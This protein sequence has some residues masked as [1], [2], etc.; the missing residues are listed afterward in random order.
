M[1]TEKNLM[2][3]EIGNTKFKGYFR[4]FEH[5]GVLIYSLWIPKE[6]PIDPTYPKYTNGT[7]IEHTNLRIE[8]PKEWGKE[9]VAQTHLFFRVK[10]VPFEYTHFFLIE[11][12]GACAQ[13]CSERTEDEIKLLLV[14][15]ILGLADNTSVLKE[16]APNSKG[17]YK[18]KELKVGYKIH[19]DVLTVV[20]LFPFS[21]ELRED[22]PSKFQLKVLDT[23]NH[24]QKV[25]QVPMYFRGNY[26]KMHDHNRFEL[27]ARGETFRICSGYDRG[28]LQNLIHTYLKQSFFKDGVLKDSALVPPVKEPEKPAFLLS[29]N[30]PPWYNLFSEVE[31]C[32]K[33]R[34]YRAA[35]F[36]HRDVYA[37]LI[38]IHPDKLLGVPELIRLRRIEGIPDD[39]ML[40]RV[41]FSEARNAFVFFFLHPSFEGVPIYRDFPSVEGVFKETVYKYRRV[42]E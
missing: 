20:F 41:S 38:Q 9:G 31:R 10:Y 18:M 35:C 34:R 39:A 7:Y 13:R 16:V 5:S 28:I 29:E 26:F 40:E 19:A 8:E 12:R 32:Q 42:E 1:S 17:D 36:S 33:E 3:F 22:V 2:E 15:S 11:A 27:E 21:E 4:V 23:I 14:K 6:V 30:A 24:N 25:A 37:W